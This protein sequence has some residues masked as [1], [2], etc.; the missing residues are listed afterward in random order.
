[1]TQS[2]IDHPNTFSVI[3][4]STTTPVLSLAGAIEIASLGMKIPAEVLKL[5]KKVFGRNKAP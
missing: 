2:G 3:V 1:M 4:S 5:V